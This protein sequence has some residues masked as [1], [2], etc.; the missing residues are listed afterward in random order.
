MFRI[1]LY[2]H[3]HFHKWIPQYGSVL[4][5]MDN[6]EGHCTCGFLGQGIFWVGHIFEDCP[7]FDSQK[8]GDW[9]YGESK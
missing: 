6:A 3:F 2:T 7:W 4:K 1:H 5:K 8:D 9:S